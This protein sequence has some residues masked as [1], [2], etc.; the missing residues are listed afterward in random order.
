MEPAAYMRA[1]S[2]EVHKFIACRSRFAINS[3]V[4]F[5][6]RPHR[7][8]LLFQ[9]YRFSTVTKE[10]GIPGAL[11]RLIRHRPSTLILS[12]N[13][14]SAVRSDQIERSSERN[15]ILEE[16]QAGVVHVMDAINHDGVIRSRDQ[17]G[18][19]G[20]EHDE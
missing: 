20:K 13:R 3:T 2:F 14:S 18:A 17:H 12:R 5:L 7:T 10:P 15:N 8:F 16:K 6:P 4:C 19:C 1:L 11:S 9:F